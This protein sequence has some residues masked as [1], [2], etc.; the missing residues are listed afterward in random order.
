MSGR[1]WPDVL[2]DTQPENR[3]PGRVGLAIR[4]VRAMPRE[5]TAVIGRTI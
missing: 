3:V 1:V 5:C 4:S 2:L